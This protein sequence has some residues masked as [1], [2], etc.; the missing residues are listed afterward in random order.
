MRAAPLATAGRAR[1]D[2][3]LA[4][5]GPATM[6]DDRVYKRGALTLHALRLT[7]GD[8]AFFDLLREWVER[9]GGG[10]ARRPTSRRWPRRSVASPST[11]SSTRG[12][13]RPRF[14]RF[15]SDDAEP[16]RASTASCG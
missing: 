15:P 16:L 7:V 12:C 3:L 2:L 5:P 6:F 11:V 10:T 13:D 14:P 8:D 1:Q 4:D 9:F